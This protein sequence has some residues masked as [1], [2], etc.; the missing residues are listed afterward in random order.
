VEGLKDAGFY[1]EQL[2]R[3]SFQIPL[4]FQ[5]L[6]AGGRALNAAIRMPSALRG[7]LADQLSRGVL[8]LTKAD[9]DQD[10]PN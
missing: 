4:R 5:P 7:T 2:D 6:E 1:V 10:R 8:Y 9:G 3:G